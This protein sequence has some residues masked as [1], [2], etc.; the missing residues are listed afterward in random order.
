[1]TALRPNPAEAIDPARVARAVAEVIARRRGAAA[2][3][4][5][6]LVVNV[7]ARH[8]HITAEH[9]A[10]LF[11]PGA[12]LTP[13]RWLYQEGQFA[14]EQ[15]VDLLG[16]RRR[17]LPGVRIL[18]PVRPATQIELAFSDAVTLGLDL[19]VR[20]SGNIAGT[21]GCL[22]LG[23]RGRLELGEGLIRAQRHVHMPPRAAQRYGVK[24]GDDLELCVDHPTCPT[25]LRGVKVR[26]DPAFRLEVH[27]DT[28]EGNACDLAH[29]LGVRLAHPQRTAG[30]R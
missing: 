3:A 20:M 27:I 14:S 24:H 29:A 13:M 10:V 9:L 12:R 17:L 11:G 15:T 26:V 16:P 23:P 1:M 25:L 30:E 28:D 22:V 19:P 5:D 21:P 7:S 18:G 2:P 8:M 6:E 4:T